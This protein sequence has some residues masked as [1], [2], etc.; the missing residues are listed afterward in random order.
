MDECGFANVD[1]Y[2]LIELLVKDIQHLESKVVWLRYSFSWYLPK[3]DGVMLR[4]EIFSALAGAYY[5]L[6]AYQQFITD[7]CDGQDPMQ[8]DYY[9]E[10]L[11]SLSTGSGVVSY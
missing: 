1:Y 5:D 3:Y 8:C 11:L 2:R 7:Y 9:S 4:C 10:N 6:P